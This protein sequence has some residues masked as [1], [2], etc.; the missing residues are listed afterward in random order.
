MHVI[1]HLYCIVTLA[2]P[3][4][5]PVASGR[6]VTS[7][8]H[9]VEADIV[10]VRHQGKQNQFLHLVDR[11]VKW[12]SEII[13]VHRF[14]RIDLARIFVYTYILHIYIIPKK[15]NKKLKKTYVFCWSYMFFVFYLSKN[16]I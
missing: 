7:F 9:E 8:N 15:N 10:F 11:A 1:H 2:N 5:I 6:L 13:L 12:F 16:D 14:D 4:F 3:R